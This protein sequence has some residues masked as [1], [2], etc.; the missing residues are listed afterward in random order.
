MI[1]NMRSDLLLGAFGFLGVVA[2]ASAGGSTEEI[3]NALDKR[4]YSTK[5][6]I[7]FILVDDLDQKLNSMDYMPL[8]KKHIYDEG[9]NFPQHYCTVSLCCPA[10]ATLLTGM[11]AHNHNVT[12]VSAPAGGYQKF[13]DQ[14]NNAYLP[15]WFREAGYSTYYTGKLMNEYSITTFANPLPRGWTDY[16]FLADP[17]TYSYSNPILVNNGLPKEY[18]NTYNTDLI[19]NK[20]FDH[21]DMAAKSGK[22]FFIALAPIAPHSEV[23]VTL[24]T[25]DIVTG[26]PRPAQ[27]HV[28]LFPDAKVPRTANFNP[29]DPSGASWVRHLPQLNDSGVEYNDNWYRARLQALQA[30]DEMVDSFMKKLEAKNL[31]DN[32]YVVFT[33]DNGFHISQH[34]L[35]PGKTCGYEEDINV[36]LAIRGPGIRKGHTSYSVSAHVDILPT[37]FKIA[38][39]PQRD[40]FDGQPIALTE[41]D[42]ANTDQIKI[43]HANIEMWKTTYSALKKRQSSIPAANTYKSVRL[44]GKGYSL[45]YSVWCTNEHELYDMSVSY[46]KNIFFPL[47][48]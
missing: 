31:L 8:T 6:N 23:N 11:N 2:T 45:Y 44:I 4:D 26:P 9:T 25:Q 24:S 41:E 10:R 27:R 17:G 32:T 5:P 20:S 18:K 3:I 1:L 7:V 37:L 33:S 19:A 12:D 15:I 36:P 39:I 16:N 29:D 14:F 46:N 21:L 48:C 34:R 35:T 13:A 38:G 22:P 30:V 42:E 40:S 28:G 47:W 43:E